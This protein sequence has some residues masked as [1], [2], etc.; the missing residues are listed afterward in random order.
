M[1]KPLRIVTNNAITT[2]EHSLYLNPAKYLVPPELRL[3]VFAHDNGF[4][5]KVY[6]RRFMRLKPFIS[7]RAMVRDTYKEYIR[8]KFKQEKYARKRL[9]VLGNDHDKLTFL[10]ND[11]NDN[12]HLLS[13][14]HNTL[15]FIVKATSHISPEIED[16]EGL[17]VDNSYCR[18]ILKNLLTIEYEKQ[19]KISHSKDPSEMYD[20]LRISFNYLQGDA[21]SRV[22]NKSKSKMYSNSA[23]FREYD[24]FLVL[25]NETIGT[26]L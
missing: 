17:T 25:L 20:E 13:R 8:Y 1:N 16:V 18:K 10:T 6:Y 19:S 2:A 3:C 21:D 23:V 15:T 14:I 9:L 11:V 4:L 5:C 26:M 22:N 12:S 7:N 24:I